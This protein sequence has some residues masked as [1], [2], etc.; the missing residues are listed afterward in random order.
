MT[1]TTTSEDSHNMIIL[2]FGPQN[3]VISSGLVESTIELLEIVFEC[4]DLH[5]R[6]FALHIVLK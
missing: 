1:V 4:F 5:F 3:L 6:Q 2:H